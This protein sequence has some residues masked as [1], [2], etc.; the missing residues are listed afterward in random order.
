M[1]DTEADLDDPAMKGSPGPHH[2]RCLDASTASIYAGSWPAIEADAPGETLMLYAVIVG[3]ATMENRTT[4]LHVLAVH[5]DLALHE[6]MRL[7]GERPP[8]TVG[9]LRRLP[10]DLPA[11]GEVLRL[12]ARGQGPVTVNSTASRRERRLRDLTGRP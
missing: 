11:V 6:A 5:R 3:T 2:S 4:E 1:T 9:H 12:D 10:A 7:L 8:D